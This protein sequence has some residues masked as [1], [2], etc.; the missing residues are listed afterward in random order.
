MG[1]PNDVSPHLTIKCPKNP[2]YERFHVYL[3]GGQG[4]RRP[5]FHT[6]HKEG[7]AGRTWKK[8]ARQIRMMKGGNLEDEGYTTN[9]VFNDKYGIWWTEIRVIPLYPIPKR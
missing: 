9:D 3:K 6:K 2:H 8:S 7:V 5:L 4:R 1:H